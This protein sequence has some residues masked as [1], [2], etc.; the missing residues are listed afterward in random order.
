MVKIGDNPDNFWRQT[1]MMWLPDWEP[2]RPDFLV[3]G[4]I[5]NRQIALR[6]ATKIFVCLMLS[7]KY[8]NLRWFY[9]KLCTKIIFLSIKFCY[10]CRNIALAGHI[11][12]AGLSLTKSVID[13]MHTDF[14][15][16]LVLKNCRIADH[17]CDK[18]IWGPHWFF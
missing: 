11:R 2:Y 12:P 13:N 18:R 15:K 1:S 10:R 7:P 8:L 14:K 3:R 6:A 4:P 17:L 5:F 9:W 16:A